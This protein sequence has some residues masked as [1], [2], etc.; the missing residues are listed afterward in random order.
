MYPQNIPYAYCM[1]A[2]VNIIIKI[3]GKISS[4]SSFTRPPLLTSHLTSLT[5]FS[6]QI[7][8]VLAL[9]LSSLSSS[10]N[11]PRG[12]S[13]TNI[14]RS[15]VVSPDILRLLHYSA[16]PPSETGVPQA[17]HTDIGSLTLL[18]SESPGLQVLPPQGVEWEFVLPHPECVI[19][20][21]G[22]GMSHYLSALPTRC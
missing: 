20:N 16:Q 19:V 18:F 15:D 4:S 2:S 6:T 11:L 10:L 8:Q 7:H 21:V 5:K 22:D 12:I 14:H 9:L 13:L 17:P 1:R 3:P